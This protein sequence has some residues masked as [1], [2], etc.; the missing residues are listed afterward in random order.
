MLYSAISSHTSGQASTKR[1]K[2]SDSVINFHRRGA[3]FTFED[4][5]G[6]VSRPDF[7]PI[8]LRSEVVH[9]LSAKV[10]TV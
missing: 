9:A 5:L 6:V 2:K 10:I 7:S 4:F 3:P 8:M 1:I